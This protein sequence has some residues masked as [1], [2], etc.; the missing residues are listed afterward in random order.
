MHYY[1]HHIGDFLKDT[2]NLSNEQLAVYLK[3]L[4]RYYTDE[5][6]FT[7]APEDIAFAVRSDEKTVQLILRHFFVQ[8]DDGWH[9]T[10]CDK[11]IAHFHGKAEKARESAN[12]RWK[13][14]N[15]LP[16]QYGRNAK[17]TKSDANQ[18][19]RTN[20]QEPVVVPPA[21]KARRKTQYPADFYPNA[22]GEAAAV[23]KGIHIP[24]ELAKFRDWH[25]AKGNTM[26]DWQAAWRTWVGNAR[27]QLGQQS[28]E[29][30][31]QRS[32]REKYEQVAP[33]I[34]ASNPAKRIDPNAFFESLS[35]SKPTLEIANG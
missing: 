22:T 29:T 1:Q 28:S 30:A 27:P 18:E 25:T 32:M 33:S 3:M 4:W 23:S 7:D 15:A 17:A 5:K 34:A 31:Y 9:Q 2:G 21:P 20:N 8:Q 14:A 10:R 26:A 19:P 24:S 13:N 11:E 12:A 35:A 16:T 6:P